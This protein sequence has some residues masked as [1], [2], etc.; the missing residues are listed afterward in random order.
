ML[1]SID[2]YNIKSGAAYPALAKFDIHEVISKNSN[3]WFNQPL[4]AA[5]DSML[6]FVVMEGEFHWHKHE[7][8]DELFFVL[9]GELFVDIGDE[10][11]TL[12]PGQGIAVSCGVLHRTRALE[13][14]VLLVVAAADA[15]VLG[16]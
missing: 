4:V 7:A 3:P 15:N 13:R 8:E 14:T 1:D 6:R 5:N 10:T 11:Q 16:D 12:R 9:E 2:R